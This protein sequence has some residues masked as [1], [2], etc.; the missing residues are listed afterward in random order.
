MSALNDDLGGMLNVLVDVPRA[1]SPAE[2][3]EFLVTGVFP[4][5]S[6][7]PPEEGGAEPA[8]LDESTA[9]LWLGTLTASGLCVTSQPRNDVINDEAHRSGDADRSSLEYRALSSSERTEPA[10]P[11]GELSAEMEC[12]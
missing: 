11:V 1:M 10:T 2:V 7:P 6:V 4:D 9:R 12:D 3:E 5:L 8:E